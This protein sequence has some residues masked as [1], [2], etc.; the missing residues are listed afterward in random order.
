MAEKRLI[1]CEEPAA[2]DVQAIEEYEAAKK[3]KKLSLE[4][5]SELTK[6]NNAASDLM[7]SFS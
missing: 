3:Q 4:P 6:G 7:D 2:E 5:L 1:S